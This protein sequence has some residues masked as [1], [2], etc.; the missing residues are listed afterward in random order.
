MLGRT[1]DSFGKASSN[2]FKGGCI[3]L[4]MPVVLFMLNTKL[5]FQQWKQFV[6]NSLVH[7]WHYLLELVH[8]T[9]HYSFNIFEITIKVFSFAEPMHTIKWCSLTWYLFYLQY[10]L[11]YDSSCFNVMEKWD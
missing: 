4:I 2:M 5:G 8:L 9:L 10:G 3:S 1:F 7:K 6:Q 11:G